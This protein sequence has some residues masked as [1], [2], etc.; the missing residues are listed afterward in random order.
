MIKAEMS[1]FEKCNHFMTV[2][3]TKKLIEALQGQAMFDYNAK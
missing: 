3:S 1:N 2:N